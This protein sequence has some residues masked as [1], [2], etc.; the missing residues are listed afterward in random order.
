MHKSSIMNIMQNLIW[1]ESKTVLKLPGRLKCFS[2]WMALD[3]QIINSGN[4]QV[5]FKSS[6]DLETFENTF[7]YKF[8]KR[9]LMKL[10][11]LKHGLQWMERHS[12][13]NLLFLEDIWDD[14][15]KRRRGSAII[16]IEKSSHNWLMIFVHLIHSDTVKLIGFVRN[17]C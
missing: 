11:S 5:R 8:M 16:L 6:R 12:M 14:C 4:R 3:K 9:D 7:D 10:K 1:H 2:I 13:S 15:R 17:Y